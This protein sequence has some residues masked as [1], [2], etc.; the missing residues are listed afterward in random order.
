MAE[1]TGDRVDEVLHNGVASRD[2]RYGLES[3]TVL[4]AQRLEPEK[5]TWTA[6]RAWY[7]SGLVD[8]GWR[9]DVAGEGAER[10]TLQARVAGEDVR[11]VTFLGQVSDVAERMSHAGLL[12]ASAPAEPLGLTVLEAMASGLPV[13]AAD[14][15]GHR[16]S[17]GADD[18]LAFPPRDVSR[19]PRPAPQRPTTRSCGWRLSDRV[20]APQRQLFDVERHVDRLIEVYGEVAGR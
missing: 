12:L 5:D 20:R 1:R 14:A 3:R 2:D 17:L 18:E 11:G 19:P 8:E 6:L 13:V 7:E 16:E 10:A 4:V 9:L 15:G